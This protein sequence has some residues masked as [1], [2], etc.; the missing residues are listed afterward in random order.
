[1]EDN[2]VDYDDENLTLSIQLRNGEN[3]ETVQVKL[4]DLEEFLGLNKGKIVYHRFKPKRK[5][6]IDPEEVE[7]S[8]D[9]T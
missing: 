5:R 6:L 4:D 3:I 7:E 8:K 1:M 2:I 9:K